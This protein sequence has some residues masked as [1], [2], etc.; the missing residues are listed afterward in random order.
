MKI[1]IRRIF[2]LVL[3]TMLVASPRGGEAQTGSSK[4]PDNNQLPM[5]RIYYLPP[6][7]YFHAPLIVQ[8]KQEI[9]DGYS[10]VPRSP[11]GRRVYVSIEDMQKFLI[12]LRRLRLQWTLPRPS[13]PPDSIKPQD[14]DGTVRFS[15]FSKGKVREAH[16]N[17]AKLCQVM[18]RLDG[19]FSQK[20]AL[21]EFQLFRVGYGCVVPGFKRDEFPEHDSQQ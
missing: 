8:A 13:G 15:W 21:W 2:L 18:Q 4:S 10:A 19:S 17:P 5:V 6:N 11:E 3:L 20:R 7:S 12:S 16:L 14:A 1:T 9:K